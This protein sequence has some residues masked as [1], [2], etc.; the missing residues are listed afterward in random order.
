MTLEASCLYTRGGSVPL[1]GLNELA[2]QHA[3]PPRHFLVLTSSGLLTYIKSRPVDELRKLLIARTRSTDDADIQRFFAKYGVKEA[4]AMSLIIACA[5]PNQYSVADL[6]DASMATS[7]LTAIATDKKRMA[8][9]YA[10]SL[11]LKVI[12]PY[13][14]LSFG[15]VGCVTDGGKDEKNGSFSTFSAAAAA[16]AGSGGSKALVDVASPNRYAVSKVSDE[17]LE[18]WA[19]QAYFRFGA[20][21]TCCFYFSVRARARVLFFV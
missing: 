11:R 13:L 15:W 9:S 16:A 3:L 7:K 8:D 21:R 14:V 2:T 18:M 10:L 6:L 19:R 4:C 1:V 5:P 12:L 20:I 17:E